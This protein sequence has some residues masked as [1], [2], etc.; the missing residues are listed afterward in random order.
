MFDALLAQM[1]N[2][3]HREAVT[4]YT[5][6]YNRLLPATLVPL[7][8]EFLKSRFQVI[9]LVEPDLVRRFSLLAGTEAFLLAI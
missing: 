6:R 5:K 1:S 2:Q 3:P 7:K 4:R 9:P 8:G